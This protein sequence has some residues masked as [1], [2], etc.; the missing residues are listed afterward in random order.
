MKKLSEHIIEK[1]KINKDYINPNNELDNILEE[2]YKHRLDRHYFVSIPD[3]PH[4]L[5]LMSMMISENNFKYESDEQ[6]NEIRNKIREFNKYD[7]IWHCFKNDYCEKLLSDM[8]KNHIEL[9]E[10]AYDDNSSFSIEMADTNKFLLLIFGTNDK[11]NIY[12]SKK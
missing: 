10:L 5:A 11:Y 3:I 9:D 6:K 8:I 2:F 4:I 1:L 12:I 7:E